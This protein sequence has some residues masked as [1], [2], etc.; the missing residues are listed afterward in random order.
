[1]EN[2]TRDNLTDK[3]TWMRLIYIVLFAVAFNIAEILIAIITVVQFF[4]ALFTKAPNARLK[5]LGGDLGAYVRDVTG[6]L[7][8][9]TDH[10]PY[11]VSDWGQPDVSQPGASGP[12]PTPKPEAKPKP[13]PRKKPAARKPA[14]RKPAAKKT[15][16]KKPPPAEDAPE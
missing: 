11:P 16:A 13:A 4:T 3:S 5:A 9:Q 2:Q 6:F 15:A 8:Y 10:M 1:M 14:P 12:D 7:T